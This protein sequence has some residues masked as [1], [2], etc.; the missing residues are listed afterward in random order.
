[1]EQSEMC[2]LSLSLSVWLSTVEPV[3]ACAS[4][5]PV[6]ACMP[7]YVYAHASVHVSERMRLAMPNL[8]GERFSVKVRVPLKREEREAK[9]RA[10]LYIYGWKF[11]DAKSRQTFSVSQD[12]GSSLN[13]HELLNRERDPWVLGRG[14]D[15]RGE[16]GEGERRNQARSK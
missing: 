4:V 5:W 11:H 7:V 6:A 8:P 15:E 9:D 2:V 1:M 13:I 14:A 16:N 12:Y 3:Y 10:W